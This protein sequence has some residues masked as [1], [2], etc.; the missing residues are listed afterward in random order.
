MYFF[1]DEEPSPKKGRNTSNV[2]LELYQDPEEI[3]MLVPDPSLS[4]AKAVCRL[5]DHAK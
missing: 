3:H 2:W 4:G 1:I 5:T